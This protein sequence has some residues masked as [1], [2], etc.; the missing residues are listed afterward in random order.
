MGLTDKA[1]H[2]PAHIA[3]N[4]GCVD[5]LKAIYACQPPPRTIDI[6][7]VKS[8]NGLT[9]LH[10][11]ARFNQFEAVKYL[12]EV[13]L[14]VNDVDVQGETPAHKAGRAMNQ[15]MVKYFQGHGC[16]MEA[17]NNEVSQSVS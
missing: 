9:P 11:A 6:L 7:N 2:T 14:D 13:G 4:A 5:A 17:L 1:G 16:E 12:V 8:K 3:A 10:V 15:T